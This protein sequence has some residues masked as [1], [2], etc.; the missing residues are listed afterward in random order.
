MT[1]KPLEKTGGNQLCIVLVLNKKVEL[2]G[3]YYFLGGHFA[4]IFEDWTCGEIHRREHLLWVTT[5][6]ASAAN[7]DACSGLSHLIIS[8][9]IYLLSPDVY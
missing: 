3:L 6:P 5:V 9:A 8:V 4:V 2:N 7:G 1:M